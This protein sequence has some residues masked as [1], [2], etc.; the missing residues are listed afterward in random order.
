MFVCRKVTE[1][2][3]ELERLSF[4]TETQP[5]ATYAHGL[6][7]KWN[8]PSHTTLNISNHLYPLEIAMIK[9][10]PTLT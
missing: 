9:F 5:R 8:Y 2:C 4:I 1:W 3:A 6:A 10:I 7:G